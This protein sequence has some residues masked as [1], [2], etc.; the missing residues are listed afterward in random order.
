MRDEFGTGIAIVTHN[1]GL[2]SYMAD[3]VAVMR[4]G[5][6]IEYGP[7]RDVIDF[8]QQEY[9]RQLIASVPRIRRS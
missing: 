1:I 2:V 8:P 9:T 3:K 7:T 6:L 4:Q 5:R